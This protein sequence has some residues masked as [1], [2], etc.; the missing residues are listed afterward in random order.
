MNKH[1]HAGL[2]VAAENQ[3]RVDELLT[4]YCER[5]YQD[6]HATAPP[7]DKPTS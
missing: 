7:P 4:A 3:A 6:F 1:H 5:F 2:I